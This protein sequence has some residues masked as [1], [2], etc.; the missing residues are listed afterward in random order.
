M[1]EASIAAVMGE[2]GGELS[3]TGAALGEGTVVA[4]AESAD[5]GGDEAI[6]DTGDDTGD[7]SDDVSD[8]TVDDD[9]DE[10]IDF[11]DDGNQISGAPGGVPLSTADF[12][13][14]FDPGHIDRAIG[15]L[16]PFD[17]PDSGD[18]HLDLDNVGVRSRFDALGSFVETG[19]DGVAAVGEAFDHLLPMGDDYH[20]GTGS[21][22]L[23]SSHGGETSGASGSS[24][25]GA[26]AVIVPPVPA[27]ELY[28]IREDHAVSGNL[29]DN[30]TLPNGYT[31]LRVHPP[32]L[33]DLKVDGRGNF[34]FTPPEHF[35]GTVV[36]TYSYKD[37][38]TGERYHS[39]AT[40]E[41]EAVA[42]RP[43][44]TA[45]ATPYTTDEDTPV[46]LD[47]LGGAL[48][49]RDGSEVLTYRIEKVPPGASFTNGVGVP[50]GTDLGGGVWV[51]TRGELERGPV[52]VPPTDLHG[53]IPLRLV[54]VATERSNGDEAERAT[55][56][57][58]VIAPV[59]D[60]VTL[61]PNEGAGPTGS[62]GR[63]IT[64]TDEDT[65]AAFGATIEAA[66]S[67][68]DSTDGSEHFA[69]FTISGLTGTL[70]TGTPTPGVD[71]VYDA[72]AGTVSLTLLPGGTE[73]DLRD[74][75]AKL[76]LT[77]PKDSDADIPLSITV[78][79]DDAG[80]TG[81]FVVAHTI[82]VA[83]V[84]DPP[85]IVVLDGGGSPAVMPVE[86]LED[87]NLP[88]PIAVDV[89]DT[90]G[91][92]N[93][94]HVRIEGLPPGF[95]FQGLTPEPDGSYLITGTTAAIQATLAALVIV[96]PAN[97]DDDF[98]LTV[99]VVSRET[100]P[101]TSGGDAG[102][103]AVPTAETVITIPVVFKAVFDPATITGTSA[104]DED[105]TVN[106]GANIVIT[107]D[108]VADGSET[109]T[110][111]VVA[112]VPTGAA[113]GYP[114]DGTM[115]AVP[116]A[117]VTITTD[118]LG[119]PVITIERTVGGTEADLLAALADLTL[120]PPADSDRD[121]TLSIAV[122][123]TDNDGVTNT[124]TGSHDIAVAAI[125]DPA[126][127][128]IPSPIVGLEDQP[129]PLAFSVAR[130]D[131]DPSQATAS[132]AI[133][134]V[135]IG[136]IPTGFVLTSTS[137]AATLTLNP[138][139]T[140]T[141]TGPDLS[142]PVANDAA[143]ND[144]LA[145]LVLTPAPGGVRTHVDDDFTLSVAVTTIETNLDGGQ[146][147]TERDTRSFAVPVT[148][149]PV[150]DAVTIAGA[151]TVVEDHSVNFGADITLTRTDDNSAL[152][153]GPS[154]ETITGIVV[155]GI[156]AGAVLDTGTA[157]PNVAVD[158]S[159]AGEVT[160]S[161]LPGGSQGDMDAALAKLTLTPPDDSDVDIALSLAVTTVDRFGAPEQ[162]APVT[163]TG[164][165]HVI[166][167]TADA[168]GDEPTISGAASGIEDTTFALPITVTLGDTDG[169][170]VLDKVS[171]T[172]LPAGAA[173][174][175]NPADLPAGVTATAVAGGV[176]F[177]QTNA[178]F[179]TTNALIAFLQGKLSVTPPP[180]SAADFTLTVEAFNIEANLSGGGG[181]TAAAP[182]TVASVDV[183]VA[184]A[185]DAVVLAPSVTTVNED[186]DRAPVL[187]DGS[188]PFVTNIPGSV[189]FG[190]AIE[191]ALSRSADKGEFDAAD[192]SEG[193]SA[194][195]L[196]GFPAGGSVTWTDTTGVL[197]TA[198]PAGTFTL[199][200]DPGNPPADPAALEAAIRQVLA[201]FT[202]G[203]PD[204]DASDVTVSI[205]V[206]RQD[207]D[208]DTGAVL[209]SVAATGSHVITVNAVA[210]A[211]IVTG[212]TETTR[213]DVAVHLNDLSAVLRDT[214]G[215]ETLSIMIS[216]VDFDVR[217]TD[218][219]GA[220][221]TFG[222]ALDGTKTYEV[223]PAALGNV[224]FHPPAEAHG[225][226]NMTIIA[227]ATEATVAGEPTADDVAMVEAPITVIVTPVVDPVVAASSGSVVQEN[228]TF[229]LGANILESPLDGD[230]VADFSLTDLDGSQSLTIVITGFPAGV[231]AFMAP[232]F[233]LPGG[234]SASFNAGSGAFTL[235]G[236]V[237]ADVLAALAQVRSTVTEDGDQNFT[238][239]VAATTDENAP[240]S[241]VGDLAAQTTTISHDV[242]V[243]AVVD[244]PTLDVGA[245]LKSAVLEDSPFVSYPVTTA[246]N[247]NDGSETWSSVVVEFWSDGAG[248]QPEIQFTTTAGV[249]FA[250]PVAGRVVLTG[251]ASDVNAAMLSLQ[252][253]PG[254]ENDADINVRVTATA[255]ESNPSEPNSGG[256]GAVGDEIADPV[257]AVTQTFVIPVA[258]VADTPTLSGSGTGLE[259]TD[260]AVSLS[261]GHPDSAD[262]S[263]TIK[264]VA[265]AAVPD[266]FT[267][268]E[269]SLGAGTLTANPDGTYTVTG[270]SD[271]AIND[272]LQHLTL[273]FVPGGARQN[274]DT[275]FDLSVTVTTIESAPS[276]AGAGQV[277]VA[278]TSKTFAVPITVTA[279][280][281]GVTATA[282]S[283]IVEDEAAIIGADITITK[284]DTDGTEQITS[285]VVDGFP[286]GATIAY[287][288]VAG[289]PQSFVSTG[290]ETV[291]LSG[292]TEAAIRAALATL[293]VTAPAHSDTNFSLG[294]TVVTSDNDG[295]TKTDTF[296]HP[297]VVQAVADTPAVGA[298]ALVLDEDTTASI[299]IR[300]DR[301]AD[302]D[303]SETLSVRI[304]V[305]SDG[306]GPIGTLVGAAPV[307]IVVTD[308][309]GGVYVVTA[310]AVTPAD[311]EAALDAFLN[312][313]LKFSPRAE[314]S[315]VLTGTSGIKVE[316]IS[317]EAATGSELAD[318][319]HG[320]ADGTSK[321]ETATT[322]I[323]VTVNPLADLPTLANAST[324]VRENNNSSSTSDPDLVVSI[325]A[326]L[327]LAMD[328]ADGS[329]S[330][331]LTLTGFPLDAQALTFG[332]TIGGV[333]TSTDLATGTVTVSG[334]NSADV[335]AVI[336][337]LSVT[338]AD[339]SDVNFTV[340]VNGS[341][342]DSNGATSPTA[343]FTLSHDV[344][345]Q[346]VADT[347]TLTVGAATKPAVAE[348]SGFITYPV[349]VGLNDTDGSES[350]ASVVVQFSTPGSGAAPEVQFG[351]IAGVTFDTSV[352]GRVT[353]TGAA[354][355]IEAAMG[356]LQVRPGADNGEDI[357]IRVTA[358]SIESNPSEPNSTGPGVA[359]TEISVPT[360][361]LVRTF[362]IPVDPVPE[363]PSTLVLPA[364]ATGTEDTLL[365][366]G[367][368][369][370]TIPADPDGS[371]QQ[372]I[373]IDTSSYPA[374][375]LF[376][377]A[378]SSIGSVVT[379]GW[380]RIPAT[381]FSSLDVVPPAN[382]SG[383]MSLSVRGVIVDT[384]SSG[385]VTVTT[386]AS[387]LTLTFDPVADPLSTPSASHGVED[388]GAVAFG[389]DLA[390]AT[391]GIRVTDAGTGTG[392]NAETETLSQVA[393]SFPA[394][395]A[396]LTY[397]VT[398]G[399]TVGSAAVAFDGPSRTFTITSSIITGAADVALLSIVDRAQAEADIRAT[400]AGFAVT[401]GPAN[402][403]LNGLVT[404][405]ATAL[406]VNGGVADTTDTTFGHTIRIEAVA[407]TPT[408]AVVDPLGSI[409]ED[410]AGF[411]L[412]I[413]P[414]NSADADGSE[415]LSVRITVPSDALGPVGSL[416]G[417]AP[418]GVTFSSL[419]NG[420]YLV[421]AAG[422]DSA[423]REAL[424]DGFLNGGITFT[425]RTNWS[426]SLTGTNGIAVEVISTE[427]ATGIELA[428]DAFGGADG[429]SKTETVVDHID[430]VVTPVIDA[431]TV[432]GNGVGT[433]D[434]LIPVP[435]SVTLA[436]KDG[437][438]TA[439]ISLTGVVPPG[440]RIFG[441]GGAE[442]LPDGFG[443]WSLTMADVAA[444]AVLPPANYSSALSGDIVLTVA[445]VVT[446][447][448]GA[449]SSTATFVNDIHVSVTG[450]ADQPGTRTV[451]VGSD[452]D[453][454]IAIGAAVLASVGGDMNNLLVDTDGSER[455]SFVLGGL[456]AGVIPASD[457]P[458]GVIYLG[459]GAW[460]VS[461][462]A[463]ETLRLPAVHNFS[464]ENPYAGVTLRA[465]TQEMDGDQA[466]SADWPVT[467]AVTPVI[468]AATVDGFASWSMGET[469][470]EGALEAAGGISLASAANHVLVD[471]DGSETV[472]SYTFDLS[473][474]IADAGIAVRLES[475]EGV[476]AGLD[477]LVAGHITGV[478]TYDAGAG[479]ITVAAADLAGVALSGDLFLDSNIDFSIPVAAVVRDSATIGGGT[480]S[481]DK[482]ETG[483]LAIDLVGTADTPTAFASSASGSSGTELA[484]TLGGISTDTDVSLGR[485]VSEDVYY[486]VSV[487]NPGTAPPLGFTD[488]AGHI[489]GL[490]NGDGTWILTPA[491]LVG[492]HVKTP[493]G[494]S[495]T[496][497]LKLTTIAVENDGDTASASAN[498]DVIV[499]STPGGGGTPPLPPSVIVGANACNED[500]S[501]DLSVIVAPAPGDTTAPSVAIMIS[502]LPPG[503]EVTGARFNP[504]TGRWVASAAAVNLGLVTIS[505]PPDFSGTM[506]ITIEGVAT[507]ASLVKAT[508][509]PMSV[510]VEV[511]PV[512]DGV[513][514]TAS[515]AAGLE[516]TA[517]ALGIQLAEIDIDGSEWID[518]NTYVRLSS[519][520][521]LAGG[522]A[523]VTGTD[524]D[525]SIAGA[526]LVGYFRVP[527][528]DVPSLQ[529]VPAANWHGTVTV[530]VAAA[531]VEPLD[532]NDG[533][534]IVMSTGSFTVDVAAVADAP[535]V[536]APASVAGI[537]GDTIALAG[538]SASLVDTVTDNGAEVL[539]VK[540]SGVPDNSFFSAGSN[541]GD[542]SWTIPVA[543]LATL[544]FTPPRNY[545]GSMALT[546]TAIALELDGGSEAQSSVGFVVDVA[547]KA[548]KVEVLAD[549]VAIDTSLEVALDLSIRTHDHRGNLPGE[550]PPELVQIDFSGVPGGV[551]IL[552][553]GGGTV[554]DL[555][556]GSWRFLGTEDQSN[557][558]KA[559]IGADAVGGTHVIAMS[560][561]TIDATDV[562][563]TPAT[564]SFQL[565]IPNLLKGSA[566][567]DALTGGGA[568]D[569]LFGLESADLL[570]G[571][572]GT[573]R[574][575]GGDGDDT[576]TGGTGSDIL[577]G[578]AG[579][580]H[581]VWHAGDDAGATDTIV[582]GF[583]ATASGDVIDL[584]ELLPGYV[585][586]VSDI[587]DFV[588][589][590]DNGADTS[591][592]IDAGGTGNFA[593]SPD[594]VTIEGVTGLDL[595]VLKAQGNLVA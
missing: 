353:L 164:L 73:S 129:I 156:P 547:P 454:D 532:D 396:S 357:T 40:I 203:A 573:D 479:T 371:E 102:E 557:A 266:G 200:V 1:D 289:A 323:D 51:F 398:P 344:T 548:D 502:D 301:S 170:E 570:T 185:L 69:A 536:A 474:I 294:L 422:A 455:L 70:D 544:E 243:E 153:S 429:T 224:W 176:L 504:E 15:H 463:M 461:A 221:Y 404:V 175:W 42:D 29:L 44:V 369:S 91:S 286:V 439:A 512:A 319:S 26:A 45:P 314:W 522:Y 214:D 202:F 240:V 518:V 516:D 34:T 329:Q 354:A 413:D 315:G 493:S 166:T 334:A 305:P 308:L 4:T 345:V 567:I 149:D 529:I 206:T 579:S 528:A 18:S 458:S 481:V 556:S 62:G 269:S 554:T 421:T 491:E 374:G 81:T 273:V 216:G 575:V 351:V 199:A 169:S 65:P 521:T 524:A 417:G 66:L 142:D 498:F 108:D 21:G 509:S 577:D 22:R 297:I 151:S 248:N 432:K 157:T 147:T 276:E 178:S 233:V 468:D 430:V 584:S 104:V 331:S 93:L 235:G 52:F 193:V 94:D 565:T 227:T 192:V 83:A 503:A 531:S 50:V 3:G 39:T 539:S 440:T 130:S 558:L 291:T 546:M 470:T 274:L 48:V 571:G 489:V 74:A 550:N 418:G 135:V 253:R 271:A 6:D 359:G 341:T 312:G 204:H 342:T 304:T 154:S 379:A 436:D 219:L 586:G 113:I 549:N 262:G 114:G 117:V 302:D 542:G 462:A 576:L 103:I 194:V 564:D 560:V 184:P 112:D 201:T 434:T 362:V 437:S 527:T 356:S 580:D 160:L 36:V 33:G 239:T 543:S 260:I 299:V 12:N 215:S 256:P 469:V 300:P 392:N 208:P 563:A 438:E 171:I 279:V 561:V 85:S 89:T 180:Q 377:S 535:L 30:D 471:D 407:D 251:S 106:F 480:V 447:A 268:S 159:V 585:E 589:V 456:P 411:A 445:T 513:A 320:G 361:S 296:T 488:G 275:E 158:T 402:T 9:A 395:T 400:L 514:I 450:A 280:A 10:D 23:Y 90:D 424:L 264:S 58:I 566:G 250:T 538:L 277:S 59:P 387:P 321:T 360:A 405:T 316:A 388:L 2:D 293:A 508:T 229:A 492:L 467:I 533:D 380:L 309:G 252:V 173:I 386:A 72:L 408:V 110:K 140:V 311:S 143:I 28:L 490:D 394:D 245:A 82:T 68:A 594:V 119:N 105:H 98:T 378:G 79:T 444:L 148:V 376:Q 177:D 258:A 555:G 588:Q 282:A 167:V 270:P 393:L 183:V 385:S 328:D 174:S 399:A 111:V 220:E 346:A 211:P 196:S 283:T 465:V 442:I 530:E 433:E 189:V 288:D 537:E 232:G 336:G 213:E 187:S 292:G 261:A 76:Q 410:S 75:L 523:V 307:G 7:D 25:L 448:S 355:D 572:G 107:R 500:G 295:S 77:P 322:F 198:G 64:A 510:P 144:V 141:V 496:A 449:S 222:I 507:N 278:E 306:S 384:S 406:D 368:F 569:I 134:T 494:A 541:N 370:I 335:L 78:T 545:S 515:P 290:A 67:K 190:A 139:G 347:P 11:D 5:G 420:V 249:T 453:Q 53:T 205:A 60:E 49:D 363:T 582:G 593:G 101:T 327:G 428:D 483:N 416:S 423:A 210:D 247:D 333:T 551:S 487:L 123:T 182:S 241:E 478:F 218:D 236:A 121:I 501:F 485:V 246:L 587:A 186:E 415:T 409:A 24:L 57:S 372:F 451:S 375:T 212:D 364:A 568:S 517:T 80:V 109:I 168:A 435:M 383:T 574:L 540:I 27:D 313:G 414:G 340:T 267:L 132:E 225:T 391:T 56:F 330:L 181:A 552:A 338:L 226:Y 163:T 92:E 136:G 242:R 553:D 161:L 337:S 150:A 460:S 84:A 427:A 562:L 63:S 390:D 145:N 17:E 317:T 365:S 477:E 146:I 209:S 389:A 238:L 223:A 505:P 8:E 441:E 61:S 127:L 484:L 259:D 37:P 38:V 325:G 343:A 559:T 497:N 590:S 172:G 20:P 381:A 473:G 476:G 443:V 310:S 592:K 358:T 207:V 217:L 87:T 31:D 525:A 124:S 47:G 95:A 14:P 281:D 41:I 162:S 459:G 137:T 35:S 452:E 526:N 382:F 284:I 43:D 401:I 96:P 118:G 412:V 367:A 265:I 116:G 520:A 326:R 472:V 591:V 254:A 71:V 464:G 165:T 133:E 234:V 403:D 88:L 348:D 125:A 475:L 446:D 126:T 272:V 97:A 350:Y 195:T 128:D 519:G 263:E 578:G 152:A 425:P 373:E 332:T 13:T 230:T 499:S 349:T 457:V 244:T 46:R 86:G 255:V 506:T 55:P 100:D 486:V 32:A 115:P 466:T 191:T 54:A 511:D 138:N 298:D 99:T 155:T 352:A 419:G 495:G 228:G 431:P 366:L 534:S 122:T 339:D 131:T 257:A 188:A 197:V 482:V 237:A 581:F 318:A 324:I 120:T 16:Q 397:T 19:I 285:I 583:D 426:G 287:T 595:N 303:G 231:T 179:V